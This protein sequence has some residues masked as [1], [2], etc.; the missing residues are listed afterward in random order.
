[1]INSIDAEKAFDRIQYP[2]MIKTLQKEGMR[3]NTSIKV[4][5]DK[6]ASYAVVK[7]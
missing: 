5:Y 1:V 7:S 2:I 6:S 4:I 3:E